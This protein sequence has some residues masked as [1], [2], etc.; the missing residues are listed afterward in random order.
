MEKYAISLDWMQ[1][2]CERSLTE[3]PKEFM[4]TRGSYVMENKTTAPR[5]GL[6]FML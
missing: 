1:Y 2:Y 4:T 5:Y 3:M 6:M